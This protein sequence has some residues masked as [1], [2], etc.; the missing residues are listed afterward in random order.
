MA[1]KVTV[2]KDRRLVE[3]PPAGNYTRLLTVSLLLVLP[4]PPLV[5]ALAVVAAFLAVPEVLLGLF[6][7]PAAQIRP[8]RPEQ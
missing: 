7:N 4:F 8:P 1:K 3:E 6:L 5:W 2:P